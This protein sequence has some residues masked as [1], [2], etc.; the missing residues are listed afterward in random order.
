M[1]GSALQTPEARDIVLDA[2]NL[3]KS[4]GGVHA[5]QNVSIHVVD[6]EIVGLIGP[7]GSGKTTL[8]NLLAG[9][10]RP[11]A[12][13]IVFRGQ[14]IAGRSAN[15]IAR[16]GLIRSWQ[17]P[18][19]IGSLTVR[20]NVELGS[21]ASGRGGPTQETRIAELLEKF[22]LGAVSHRRATELPYG[23]QKIVALARTFAAQ[24]TLLMLDEPLA[25]LSMPEQQQ[26]VGYIREFQNRG[27][28]IIVDHAFSVMAKLC[29][30]LAVLN[31]GQ[32]LAEGTP[33]E[34]S[35]DRRVAEVY[36]G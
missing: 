30:R 34:I 18:R 21:V 1:I 8:L 32:K 10:Y 2:R 4:F 3:V 9:F 12:G 6:R 25:G 26:M 31:S 35:A 24:P 16:L 23:K 7:N 20:E 29:D 27:S 19:T 11:D 28:V 33:A 13:S 5:T 15:Q 22:E 17:D 14:P 36:L